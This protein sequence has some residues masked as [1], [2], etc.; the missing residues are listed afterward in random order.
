M[1]LRGL[2]ELLAVPMVRVLMV[3][4]FVRSDAV[5]ATPLASGPSLDSFLPPPLV[6]PVKNHVALPVSAS[7]KKQPEVVP[8][9]THGGK[10]CSRKVLEGRHC[11]GK[12]AKPLSALLY[13][14]W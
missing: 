10:D 1:P 8:M 9:E 7:S 13:G 6:E 14:F 11:R 3:G 12:G 4:L 5:T 2:P